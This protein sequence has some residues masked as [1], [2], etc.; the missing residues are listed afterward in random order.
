MEQ[1]IDFHKVRKDTLSDVMAF[2]HTM[3]ADNN[4]E[5]YTADF[6]DLCKKSLSY[7]II[8]ENTVGDIA[9]EWRRLALKLTLRIRDAVNDHEQLEIMETF[10]IICHRINYAIENFPHEE[11]PI[12]NNGE[13]IKLSKSN[14]DSIV[15][16]VDIEKNQSTAESLVVIFQA[17]KNVGVY[18]KTVKNKDIA[19][20]I[21]KIFG[22]SPVKIA[23][24]LR[25]GKQWSIDIEL[26]SYKRGLKLL[27][28]AHDELEAYVESIS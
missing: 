6:H 8:I 15:I 10:S 17:L 13:Y 24:K 12:I 3:E 21:H 16:N 22:H 27:K 9:K 11:V 18:S 25:K 19:E 7:P 5:I 4:R 14:E 2:L 1:G 23:Q 26:S 20:H 28:D